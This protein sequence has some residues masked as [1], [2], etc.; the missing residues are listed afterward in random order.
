MTTTWNAIN[1]SGKPVVTVSQVSTVTSGADYGSN[2]PGTQTNGIQEALNNSGGAIVVLL[3]GVFPCST[4]IVLPIGQELVGSGEGETVVTVSGYAG[5]VLYVPTNSNSTSKNLTYCRGIQFVGDSNSTAILELEG[6]C[7]FRGEN[8]TLEG[9]G[10]GDG[11]QLYNGSSTEFCEMNVFSS[12]RIP[13]SANG[14]HFKLGAAGS[15]S[16]SHNHFYGVWIGIPPSS[17]YY[18]I[19]VDPYARPYANFFDAHIWMTATSGYTPIGLYNNGGVMDE[20]AVFLTVENGGTAGYGVGIMFDGWTVAPSAAKMR[21][22]TMESTGLGLAQGIAYMNMPTPASINN[23]PYVDTSPFATGDSSFGQV[24]GGWIWERGRNYVT[25]LPANP[26]GTTKTSYVM[27]G[28]G[29]SFQLTPMFSGKIR[30]RLYGFG[31]TNGAQ[32]TMY[33]QPAYG[34]G[35]PP[36]NT[37]GTT[38]AIGTTCGRTLAVVPPAAGAYAA[39]AEEF[40]VS[41]LTVGTTYWFDLQFETNNSS[42]EAILGAISGTIEEI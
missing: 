34:T 36:S 16:F 6:V 3:P 39:W 22:F 14:I 40:E 29:A 19:Y 21:A 20:S 13:N 25:A 24:F 2:T 4:G 32:A 11:L 33:I 37:N 35:N 5:P 15:N 7:G 27:A 42:Y 30:V 41:G 17:S 38:S 12:I 8:L 28:L 31:T 10:V 26:S 18:G 9:A 23:Y 1:S